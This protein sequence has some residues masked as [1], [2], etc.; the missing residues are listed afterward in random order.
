[1]K[2]LVRGK[3]GLERKGNDDL[4]KCFAPTLEARGLTSTK[5][6]E[7]ENSLSTHN[8]IGRARIELTCVPLWDRCRSY[9]LASRMR[10]RLNM[11]ITIE[12]S[13]QRTASHPS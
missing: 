11:K 8:T 1:M 13:D 7:N 12:D 3:E 10:N 4:A 2:F 9:L 6:T 5:D